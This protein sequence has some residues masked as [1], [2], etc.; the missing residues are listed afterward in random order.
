MYTLLI[1]WQK[2]S[3]SDKYDELQEY[4]ADLI[5]IYRVEDMK[6]TF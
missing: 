4:M 2:V 3:V 6:I 1:K 5:G